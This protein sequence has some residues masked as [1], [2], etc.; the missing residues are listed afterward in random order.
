LRKICVAEEGYEA[1]AAALRRTT[2]QDNPQVEAV[3]RGIIADVQARGDAALLELGR[4]FDSPSL[5]T[6]EVSKE[7]WDAACS[8]VDEASQETVLIAAANITAFHEHQKRT[9]WLDMQEGVVTGQ[10]VRPLKRVGLY[11]PGGTAVYPSS[12]LMCGLP[13]RVAG[14]EELIMC[15]PCGKNGKLHPLVLFA[16]RLAGISRVFKVG[17]AQAIAAMAFGT[18]TVPVVDKVAGPG[19][20]YVNIAKKMLWGMVDIDMLAGPSEVC[21]IADE[22][23]NPA[24]AAADML[25][26]AEHDPDCAAYL[27]TTSKAIAEATEKELESQMS[28]LPRKDIL[29]QALDEQGAIII[30]ESL[31]QACDL[32][33]VCAPEH[34]ALMV[35]DPFAA[36]G[37]IRSAGAILMGDY[38]PQ[39]L[40]D[41]LAGP[42]HTL[43][44]SGTARFTSPL[45]V[46]TFI[47]KSS[48]IYYTKDA[49]EKV[50][51]A[52]TQFATVEGFEA[53]SAAVTARFP[54]EN[55]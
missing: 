7:E 53:H 6:I 30:A 49:L 16:A 4:R 44:T 1:A 24:F 34:L 46:D 42:S 8:E 29:R 25:T 15:T 19:N 20:A 52:L 22:G 32:A 9:S 38:A 33:N 2:L 18:Q 28:R 40:G 12:V 5:K 17:G 41:Y 50:A 23:A 37:S 10:M 27:I 35:R 39:T 36:L 51:P 54:D 43:P 45:H 21:V 3:V 14:V 55:I 26:Q 31:A 11:V 47:K 13:A 48:F